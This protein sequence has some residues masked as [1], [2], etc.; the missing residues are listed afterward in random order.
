MLD[1]TDKFY[2]ENHRDVDPAVLAETTGATVKAI[3]AFLKK[4]PPVAQPEAPKP[5]PLAEKVGQF[6]V[7]KGTVA[8]TQAQ[9][10]LGDEMAKVDPQAFYDKR[11]KNCLH[12]IRP[13]EPST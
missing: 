9:S 11:L 6:V 3:K 2:I 5:P 13:D 1:V 8:M 12:K 4:L 10:M 7:S